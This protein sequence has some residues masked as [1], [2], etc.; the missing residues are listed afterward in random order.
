M[1]INT[2][3][4]ASQILLDLTKPLDTEE[5]ILAE[6]YQR[7]L[8]EDIYAE[9]SVPA[10][11]KSAYDGYAI[12][13]EDTVSATEAMPVRLRVTE[14]VPAGQIPK[15]AILP[16]E[17]ARVMTGAAIPKGADAVIMYEKT[18]FTDTA[19]FIDHPVPAGN[20]I[21]VGEDVEQGIR[22]AEKGKLLSASDVALI[23]GQGIGNI[24][25]YRKPQIGILSTGSELLKPGE[26]MEPGKIY[27][28]NPYLLS[29]YLMRYHMMPHILGN[30]SDDIASLCTALRE[31]LKMNDVVIT[32]GGVS[33]GDFD[34]MP[35]VV[36]EIGATVLFHKLK[37]KPG[38]AMLAAVKD[39]KIILALSG[40]PGAAATGLL[41]VGLPCMKRLCGQGETGFIHTTAILS[42]NYPKSSKVTR[43]LK[44]KATFQ[45]GKLYFTPL[46]NQ[47]NGSV[48]SMGDCDMLAVIPSGSGPLEAERELEVYI[49]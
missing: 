25:V 12:R 33:A 49:I 11:E 16:G 32:T 1:N 18:E 30:V 28:T 3:A 21:P 14:V 9:I 29:G 36:R 40:N 17:A 31:A 8:A 26:A 34:F 35:K 2:I 4:E 38:G 15:Y 39:G 47:C 24:R 10:F 7:V 19:V 13:R 23:V 5:I 27:N 41:C 6:A 44:G 48:S 20:I 37:F 42:E 43:I 46:R 45:S 22:L